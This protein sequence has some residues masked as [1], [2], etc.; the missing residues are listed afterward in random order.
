[1]I[2]KY[3]IGSRAVRKSLYYTPNFPIHRLLEIAFFLYTPRKK[4]SSSI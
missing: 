1:M 2:F 4:K 3:G